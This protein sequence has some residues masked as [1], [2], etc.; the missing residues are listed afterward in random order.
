LGCLK[1]HSEQGSWVGGS[2]DFLYGLGSAGLMKVRRVVMGE[3]K[4]LFY[5][6]LLRASCLPLEVLA[7]REDG[8]GKENL[9]I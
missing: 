5:S 8:L 3:W 7:S 9:P 4:S 1:G 2:E 6:S